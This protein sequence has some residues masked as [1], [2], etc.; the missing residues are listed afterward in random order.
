MII[1]YYFDIMQALITF[2][3]V[4]SVLVL[5]HEFGH[6]IAA[7]IFG[8][9]AD[10]FGYGFPPRL[11]G[12]VKDHGKWKKVGRKDEKTYE[13]T[14]W[15]I[16][17]LPLG[18][19]V[20]IKG[21]N[22][23]EGG[24]DKDSFLAKPIWQ[25]IIILGAG[26]FMN[27]L[28]ATVLFVIIFTSGSPTILDG[29]PQG[30]DIQNRAVGVVNVLSDAPAGQAGLMIGD[31][32]IE[33]SGQKF[34]NYQAVQ[35]AIANQGMNEFKMKVKHRDDTVEELTLHP[36]FLKE[37]NKP[38]IG[39]ALADTG[40]VSFPFFLAIKQAVVTVF[41]YT[42]LIV[43]TFGVLIKDLVMLKGV[44]Q[45]VAGPVGIAVITGKIAKQGILPLLQ[46]AAVL[47]INLAVV[48]FLP[49][50]ALDGGRVMFLLLEKLRRKKVNPQLEARIHQIAF[51]SLIALV[52][53]VTIKDLMHYGGA[54]INGVKHLIG[55]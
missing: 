38:G 25:R 48:N 40:V 46:F 29:V 54:I 47:S 9:K 35:E 53:L 49:I 37:I 4:L 31:S 22:P 27:W 23:D 28:L 24:H 11:I 10:E 17:W 34:D 1:T 50:P 20:R 3:I 12:F 5:I 39:I 21:E 45:D 2:L 42:I 52:F 18:G 7:R 32:V 14:I 33:V 41:N 44:Q 26:V 30:A 15:S 6:Y 8:A 51:L 36:I 19:F 55:I 16:N 43:K 13:N